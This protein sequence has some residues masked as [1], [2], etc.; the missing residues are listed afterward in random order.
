M[1]R[2]TVDAL[3]VLDAGRLEKIC[4]EAEALVAEGRSEVRQQEL[5]GAMEARALQRTLIELLRST[6]ANLRLLRE[7]R[8]LRVNGIRKDDDTGLAGGDRW[9]R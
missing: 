9:V 5:R 6:D 2:E 1:L 8:G 7:L 4:A 3:S